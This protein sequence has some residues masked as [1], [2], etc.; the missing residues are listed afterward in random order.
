MKLIEI[1]V[2]FEV[3][4]VKFELNLKVFKKLLLKK[5]FGFPLLLDSSIGGAGGAFFGVCR[6]LAICFFCST[7]YFGLPLGL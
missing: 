1:V 7:L 4:E 2:N 6:S 3:F 5:F